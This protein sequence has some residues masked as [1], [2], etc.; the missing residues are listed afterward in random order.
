MY[1]TADWSVTPRPIYPAD[2]RKILDIYCHPADSARPPRRRAR[3]RFRSSTSGDR[4]PT[5]D[6]ASGS[7]R[8]RSA[9]TM[10]FAVAAAGL[11]A[12]SRLQPAA[13]RPGRSDDPRR[14]AGDRRDLRQA[15]RRTAARADAAIIVL[16]EYGL[17]DVTGPVHINRALREAG[18]LAVRDELGTE[19][20]MPARARRSPWPTISRARLRPRTGADRRRCKALLERLPGVERVL[21]RREQ[22]AIGLDH[23]RSGELV[24]IAAARSLVHVLL[25]ARRR[26]RARL[27]AH[28]RHP[29][30]ARLRPGGAVPRSGADA[31]EAESRGDAREEGAR[32]PLPD[33][34][35]SARR[36]AGA[37]LARPRHRSAGRRAGVHLVGEGRDHGTS[38]SRPPCA[39]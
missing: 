16:S 36:V 5:S 14:R 28:R 3:R 17:V 18:L 38:S 32:L 20:S 24:A 2:G 11:P 1:S 7:P 12:A 10:A 39:T 25:L 37:G 21:D 33:G 22:A 26:A 15:D 31:A 6:R 35:D 19:R 4:P 27:R 30:Q 23:E 9:S 29:P 8:R 34:R 13:A